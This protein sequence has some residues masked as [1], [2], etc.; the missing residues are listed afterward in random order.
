MYRSSVAAKV[1]FQVAWDYYRNFPDLP[2]EDEVCSNE[3]Q[4][5]ILNMRSAVHLRAAEKVKNALMKNGG[6]YIKLGQHISAMQYVLP[7]EWCTT[8]QALQDQNT[9]SS[10][11]DVDKVIKADV[12]RSIDDLFSLFDPKPIGVASLAQV[13]RAV[14]RDTGEEVAV[15]VQ[16]PMVRRYSDIDIATVT[17]MFEFIHSVFPDFKFMWLSAEMQNSLPQ[18]L[19]FRNDKS[20][21]ERVVWE[22]AKYSGIPLTVPKMIQASER[23][24]IMGY[25]NGRRC[26]DLGFLRKHSIDPESVSREIGRIFAEMTFVHGFLH[27]DPHPG[28]LFVRPCDKQTTTHGY[29]F[30]LVLLDHGLY[31]QLS[32]R[33]RY[34]YAEMWHALMK[35]DEEQIKYWSRKVSGT[36]LYQLFST[37][38]TGQ[39]WT[40]IESKALSQTTSA[41]QFSLD[42]LMDRQ[43]DILQQI[44]EILASVPPVLLLVLKTNDLLRMI[45]M[46]LFADQPPTVRQHAQLRSWLR[47]SHYCLVTIRDIRAANINH[48]LS[49]SSIAQNAK[50]LV[51]LTV[52]RLSFWFMDT[53]LSLYSTLLSIK[54]LFI[55]TRTSLI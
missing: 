13:H 18:E 55:R 35:G 21:A 19:D 6:V 31:R 29:N 38:L 32:P 10:L 9:A 15:K 39:H 23:V 17:V 37:I 25:V 40:T 7:M 24:L 33:F 5:R 22:F 27:C 11:E 30:D 54:D 45:D 42:S 51:Q 14:L 34:E 50:R 2:S 28:N 1:T 49:R 41:A 36:D 47:I 16:H 26:D 53:A 43:P 12:G 44:T 4:Q 20:N 52:N 8:M 46:K 48:N 3:E